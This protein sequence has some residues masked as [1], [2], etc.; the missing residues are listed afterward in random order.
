MPRVVSYQG[1]E[2]LRVLAGYD[3]RTSSV[4][5]FGLYGGIGWGK[6]SK[7]EDAAGTA[8]SI[9]NPAYHTLVEAGV[10]VTLFP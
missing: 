2:V 7:V 9:A 8:V 3:W 5:G 6:Y 4:L 1:W 10:R